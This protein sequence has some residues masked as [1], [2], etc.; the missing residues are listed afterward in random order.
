MSTLNK[1]FTC[2]NCGNVTL[3]DAS[4]DVKSLSEVKYGDL[5]ICDKCGEEF[6]A[7]GIKYSSIKLEVSRNY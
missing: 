4:R 5:M 7:S 6:T 2:P 1:E 3:Y